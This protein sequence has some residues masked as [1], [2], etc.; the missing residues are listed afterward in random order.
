MTRA[1]RALLWAAASIALAAG[2]SAQARADLPV[3]DT[4]ALGQWAQQLGNDVKAYALDLQRYAGEV[5][6]WA[7]QNLQWLQQIQQ[8]AT[9][10][11]QYA[12][13]L[14]MLQ[15]WVHNPSLGSALGLLNIAGL[16]NS[17]PVNAY[18]VLNL[19]N[20][21]SYGEGGL[22]EI[23]GVLSS[24]S[25]LTAGAF[26]ANHVYTP[27][28]AGWASEQLI[29]NANSI[30]GE[31]GAAQAAYTDLQAHAAVLQALRD[32]LATSS[33]PKD[34]QDTQAQIELE[35]V[36]TANEAAQ[37]TAVNAAYSAQRDAMVQRDNEKLS[38]DINN[39]VEAFPNP[40]P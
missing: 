20:G 14:T 31:Q 28:D 30:A 32:H 8:Y 39:F 40:T 21:H 18:A 26:S 29:S 1:R 22:P 19:V 2:Y 5:K 9:Q 27:T 13:E 34:V 7:T 16:S 12:N 33:S 3:I 25:N 4:A 10:L 35:Q 11:Q 15:N 23:S 36:W 17:L 6:S 37:L 38:M 24:L